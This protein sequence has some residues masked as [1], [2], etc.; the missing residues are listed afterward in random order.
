MA[1][2]DSC[3]KDCN[4]ECCQTIRITPWDKNTVC[5]PACKTTCEAS[6]S[7]CKLS[8]G[9]LPTV[10]APNTI[11]LVE[12]ALRASCASGFEVITKSVILSQGSY[13]AGSEVLLNDAKSLL[14]AAGLFGAR[15]FD[16]VSIRWGRIT[17]EGIAPDRDTIFISENYLGS[18]DLYSVA[19]I[20]GH[21]MIHVRQYRNLGTD[22]F[23]C[24]YTRKYLD[25]GA[26][27]DN[28]HPLEAE[29]YQWNTEN[30]GTVANAVNSAAMNGG[31]QSNVGYTCYTPVGYCQ[32]PSPAPV[33]WQCECS[34][35][36]GL[37]YG[38]FGTP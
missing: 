28:G 21:E 29:A 4:A 22:N 3:E 37:I 35:P 20:L 17:A 31:N 27:Q 10:A 24:E 34:S 11:E 2:S 5:E 6:K 32:Y 9:A 8:G 36:Q 7:A 12:K 13:A 25:C 14:V 33:G 15:E 19:T 18:N 38:V 30:N 23:K 1:A 26:C 16:G